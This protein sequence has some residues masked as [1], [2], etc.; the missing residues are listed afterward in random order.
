MNI[1]QATELQKHFSVRKH[2]SGRFGSLRGFFSRES[3]QVRA[4]DGIS[5]GVEPGELVAKRIRQFIQHINAARGTTVLLTT[6]DLADVQRLC[7]PIMIIDR[8]KLLFDGRL[9]TLQEQFGGKRELV[10]DFAEDYK[11][12]TVEGA[13]IIEYQD[14]RATYQFEREK[15]SASALIG[16]ISNQ[17]RVQDLAVREPDIEATIRRIYEEKLLETEPQH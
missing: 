8:G 6:H 17:Y 14:S 16:R 5:F 1:I 12:V 11:T 9:Q 7:Q 3:R 10:V 2:F 4:V 15:V 13:T